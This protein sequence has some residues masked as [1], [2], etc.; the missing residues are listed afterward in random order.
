M[1]KPL[2]SML[3]PTLAPAS[4]LALALALFSGI[5]LQ[6]AD[7]VDQLRAKL[8]SRDIPDVLVVAQSSAHVKRPEIA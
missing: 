8:F 3:A 5:A 4:A 7:R 2:R 6:A 1:K